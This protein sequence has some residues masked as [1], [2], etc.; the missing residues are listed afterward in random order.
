MTYPYGGYGMGKPLSPYQQQMYQDRINAYDQQQ[1]ANQYN[2]YMRGQQAFN[3]PQQMINCRPVS[4]YDEA[5]ASMIDLD[6]SLFVF[7]DVANKKIYT[8][9]IMLDGTASAYTDSAIQRGFDNQAVINKLNGLESGLCDG[10]Y[11]MNTS[12]LNGF[13]GTQQA[14]NNVAVAG[15]QNTNAL[16][17]QLADCCCTTNRNLDAVRYENARNTCDIVNA[18]KADGDATR[19]LMTQNE[20]QS[21]RD[22]LQTANFQLSQQ[23]QNATLISTLRPTPIPAYQ[24]CSP[25]ESA[26]MYSRYNNGCNSCCGC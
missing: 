21:L 23:A 6:G 15:M 11:A 24:T 22:E 14:I 2:G 1:Y 26:Y 5:K 18:I 13:N 19:A 16:A 3:Q 25:Y 4:S 12:L 9:Q 10:F 17:A 8:K 20:I 7:T